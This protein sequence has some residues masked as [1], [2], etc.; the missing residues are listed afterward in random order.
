MQA[1]PARA[2]PGLTGCALTAGQSLAE[3]KSQT[4]MKADSR[5]G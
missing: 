1:G 5:V 2:G 4:P 3:G